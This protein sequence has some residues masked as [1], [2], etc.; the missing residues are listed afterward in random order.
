MGEIS[1]GTAE[2]IALKNDSGVTRNYRV[3]VS[4]TLQTTTA[5]T[6]GNIGLE[7]HFGDSVDGY[8]KIDGAETIVKVNDTDYT[9]VVLTHVITLLDDEEVI[10]FGYLDAGSGTLAVDFAASTITLQEI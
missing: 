2:R 1:I 9:S 10:L 8:T 3:T 7:L 4:L 6:S 5:A